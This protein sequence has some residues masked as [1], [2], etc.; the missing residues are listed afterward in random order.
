MTDDG[1]SETRDRIVIA[2]AA[3]IAVALVALVALVRRGR[4]AT[5]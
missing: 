2:C 4:R 1:G 5:A 3:A